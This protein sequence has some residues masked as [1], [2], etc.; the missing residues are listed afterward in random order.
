M[1]AAKAKYLSTRSPCTCWP[2]ELPSN[3]SLSACALF[4]FIR[5]LVNV[6]TSSYQ[7]D[8]RIYSGLNKSLNGLA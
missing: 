3:P 6:L 4:L 5:R 1:D 8:A 2:C 7:G